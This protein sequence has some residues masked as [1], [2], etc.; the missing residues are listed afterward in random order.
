MISCI[1]I[2]NFHHIPSSC[3][4]NCTCGKRSSVHAQS[5]RVH[6]MPQSQRCRSTL[7]LD[8]R[9]KRQIDVSVTGLTR[10]YSTVQIGTVCSTRMRIACMNVCVLYIALASFIYTRDYVSQSEV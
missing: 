8:S 1:I 3:I 5:M 4:I 10:Q 2:N 9:Q 7:D 6:A